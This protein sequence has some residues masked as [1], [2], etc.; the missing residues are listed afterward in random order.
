MIFKR[1]TTAET[2]ARR[3]MLPRGLAYFPMTRAVE[4]RKTRGMIVKGS[5]MLNMIWLH[6][7]P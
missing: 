5:W 2:V 6:R 4:V 3:M 7:R 1:N